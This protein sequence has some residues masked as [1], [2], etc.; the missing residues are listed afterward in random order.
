MHEQALPGVQLSTTVGAALGIG[1]RRAHE[2]GGG[3]SGVF[4]TTSVEGSDGNASGGEGD[5]VEGE[6]VQVTTSMAALQ[7]VV[8]A[9]G[10][11]GEVIPAAPHRNSRVSGKTI[12]QLR[13]QT[14]PE[15]WTGVSE[16]VAEASFGPGSTRGATGA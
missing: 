5:E 4:S 9:H 2:G 13:A 7:E 14:D 3:K 10:V 1:T 12:D 8:A 11:G 15:A 6:E 16:T